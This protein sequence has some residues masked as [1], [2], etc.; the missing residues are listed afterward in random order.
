MNLEEFEKRLFMVYVESS[1]FPDR[2]KAIL[3]IKL[4][5]PKRN[6]NNGNSNIKKAQ[7]IEAVT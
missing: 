5:K 4:Q 3:N 7:F 6:S 2:V 1:K